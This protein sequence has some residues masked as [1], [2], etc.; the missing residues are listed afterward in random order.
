MGGLANLL[1]FSYAAIL[2]GSLALMGFPFLS[3]YYSKDVILEVAYAKF[4]VTSHFAFWLGSLSAF[5]TSFYSMRLLFL[6]FLGEVNASR[7]TI[8]H[9]HDAPILMAGPMAFL[10]IP[11]IFIG[12]LSRDIFVG[13]GTPFWGK[14]IAFS[15]ADQAVFLNAEFL[16]FYIKIVPVVC[17]TLGTLVAIAYFSLMVQ[18]FSVFHLGNTGIA[19]YTFLSKKWFL[20]KIYSEFLVQYVLSA[21]YWFSYK[22][23]D[24][25]FLEIFGPAGLAT[26][27]TTLTHNF[28]LSQTGLAYNHLRQ[29]IFGILY[30]LVALFAAYLNAPL[31][32]VLLT[33]IFGL[34]STYPSVQNH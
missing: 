15:V 21:G 33:A 34:A 4:T 18:G 26:N 6:T 24:R 25:G 31:E 29:A 13:L 14:S 2:I 32:L 22:A 7:T 27:L 12:Y 11:S 19:L 20:D 9:V 10:A 23:L 1:P 8:G 16:P 3:G 30:I 5:F 17:S 28:G